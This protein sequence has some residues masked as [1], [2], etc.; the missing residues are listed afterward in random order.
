VTVY[1]LSSVDGS[2]SDNGTTWALAKATLTGA[3][4]V[5]TSDGDVIKVDSAHS[6]SLTTDTT[7]TFGANVSVICVDRS[8]SDALAT[9][10]VIGGQAASYGISLAGGKIVKVYGMT[11]RVPGTGTKN[12]ILGGADGMHFEFES[13]AL[14]LNTTTAG[15]PLAIYLGYTPSS[16]SYH[17][18]LNCTL[19]FGNAAQSLACRGHCE[20]IGCTI[21]AGGS[22]PTT[23]ISWAGSQSEAVFEG[24]DLSKITGTIVANNTVYA[25][26]YTFHN[27]K[28]GASVTIKAAAATVLNKGNVSVYAFNCDAG[29]NHYAMYHSDAFGETTVSNTIYAN[30]G[31]K[32]DGINGASWKIITTA[33]CNYSYPYVSPWIDVYHSSGSAI[34]PYLEILRNDSSTPLKNDEIWTEWS[35]QGN[36]GSTQATIDNTDRMLPLGTA[37]D[38]TT[39]SL[40]S[41]DWAGRS[42]TNWFGKLSPASSFAAKEIGYVR[43]RICVGKPSVTVY[44]DPMIRGLT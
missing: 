40:G 6:E 42:G 26:R 22:A 37:V 13:C 36:V 16:N 2:D 10:A 44:V 39:S 25:S 1:Y 35:Y 5:A 12:M 29:D 21:D 34:T 14:E 15:G 41:L 4:A 7:Y 11:F 23:L 8:S 38:Q 33:N 24:C 3:L 31:A 28:L 30:D 27:C 9:S 32:Y 19:K 17:K 18:L 20:L 43:A